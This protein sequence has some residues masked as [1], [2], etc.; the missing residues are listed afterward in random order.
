MAENQYF[1]SAIYCLFG[2]CRYVFPLEI[3]PTIK[4]STYS[5]F[6]KLNENYIL[7]FFQKK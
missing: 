5:L 2:D 1:S 6:F 4:I 3:R 7:F